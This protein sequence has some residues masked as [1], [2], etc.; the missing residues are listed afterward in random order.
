MN[1]NTENSRVRP[2]HLPGLLIAMMIALSGCST[3]GSGSLGSSP[4]SSSVAAQPSVRD[5]LNDD[6]SEL[7]STAD[8]LSQVDRIFYVKIE[9]DDVQHVVRDITDYSGQ[10]AQRMTTLTG[11]FPALAIDHDN[12]P[13]IIQAAHDAQK[14]ATLKRFAPVV[15]DTGKVFERG[16]L[17]RLLGAV[18]QQHYLA[19]TL[20]EREPDA[21][22]A[23]IMANVSKR[24][25]GFYEEIDTLLKKRFYR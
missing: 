3:L 23:K 9:S 25:A 19:A 16:I 14:K 4:A 13:P 7:Y 8:G 2:A 5:R 12:T 24:Y 18:D 21:A 6:Y 20:A 15:G 22:L 1:I 11:E 17:I 10:L